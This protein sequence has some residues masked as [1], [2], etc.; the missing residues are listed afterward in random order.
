M[1]IEDPTLEV[2]GNVG[3]RDIVMGLRWVKE[4]I[5]NFYGDPNI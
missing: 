3:L 5:K 2:S 4:N 1:E